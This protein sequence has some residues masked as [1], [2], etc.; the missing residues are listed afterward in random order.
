MGTTIDGLFDS[1]AHGYINGKEVIIDSVSSNSFNPS[2]YKITYKFSNIEE[3]IRLGRQFD[4]EL[5]QV[6]DYF[7]D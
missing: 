7:N 5:Q 2:E 4:K 1:F 6:I 3:S